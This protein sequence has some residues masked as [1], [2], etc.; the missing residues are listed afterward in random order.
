MYI[1]YNCIFVN[2]IMTITWLKCD[3]KKPPD[4]DP[5]ESPPGGPVYKIIILPLL[6]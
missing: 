4:E 6:F 1:T 3:Y 2:I 5:L